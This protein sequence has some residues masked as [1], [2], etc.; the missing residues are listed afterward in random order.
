MMIRKSFALAQLLSSS[1]NVVCR[2]VRTSRKR[3]LPVPKSTKRLD[4]VILGEPNVG[5]SVLLNCLIKTKLAAT[6]RKRHTTRG[7][8]LGVFNHRNTQLAFYDT[9]GFVSK[10]EALRAE[11][12]TLRD[13]AEDSAGKADVVMIVIDAARSGGS[14]NIHAFAEVY[15]A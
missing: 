15:V 3:A 7:E 2:Y 10:S 5:K 1:N 4:V 11:M 9:P 8:I 14:K 6:T 13:I 12:K